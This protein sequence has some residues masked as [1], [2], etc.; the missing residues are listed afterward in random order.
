[1]ML[2]IWVSWHR[3]HLK[4][5]T[6]KYIVFLQKAKFR[7]LKTHFTDF[8]IVDLWLYRIFTVIYGSIFETSQI[9]KKSLQT[10]AMNH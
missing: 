7:Q 9:Q 1:M 4:L 8:A 5:Y 10:L 6:K 2:V 3:N